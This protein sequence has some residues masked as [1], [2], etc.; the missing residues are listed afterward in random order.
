MAIVQRLVLVVCLTVLL[1]LPATGASV[2]FRWYGDVGPF[3]GVVLSIAIFGAQIVFSRSWL[4]R[5][6][7]GPA[8]WLWRTLTHE[9]LQPMRA[10]RTSLREA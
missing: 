1:P 8:E 4:A 9:R 7:F 6:R 3:Y 2:G 5:Y 10:P